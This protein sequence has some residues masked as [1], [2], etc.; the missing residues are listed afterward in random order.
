VRGSTIIRIP[1]KKPKKEALPGRVMAWSSKITISSGLLGLN[2]EG[3][4]AL[5]YDE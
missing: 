1:D 3:N 4:A 5:K 2:V